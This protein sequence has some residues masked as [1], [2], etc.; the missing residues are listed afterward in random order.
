M[1]CG[2]GTSVVA[3][4][5]NVPIYSSNDTNSLGGLSHGVVL[6]DQCAMCGKC[7]I[8]DFGGVCPTTQCA[9][10]LLNGP[11]GGSMN[12]MCEVD[13]EKDCAWEIIYKRLKAIGRLDML[14]RVHEPKEH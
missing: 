9:K 12:G 1:G 11:C 13:G 8:A 3:S 5:V 10:E 14:D 2:S 4:V 7:I 6:H